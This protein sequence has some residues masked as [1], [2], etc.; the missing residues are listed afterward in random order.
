MRAVRVG[1][2]MKHFEELFSRE[3][4]KEV[5]CFPELITENIED[6]W[7]SGQMYTFVTQG[8][9]IIERNWAIVLDVE[10]YVVKVNE[11]MDKLG[12]DMVTFCIYIGGGE[13]HDA[14]YRFKK[15]P[16]YKLSILENALEKAITR[17]INDFDNGYDVGGCQ[18][19]ANRRN[20][21]LTEEKVL[22]EFVRNL[23]YQFLNFYVNVMSETELQEGSYLLEFTGVEVYYGG[24]EQ[25]WTALVEVSLRNIDTKETEEVDLVYETGIREMRKEPAVS[26]FREGVKYVMRGFQK[27]YPEW[28]GLGVHLFFDKS[29]EKDILEK[30][31]RGKFAKITGTEEDT[32]IIMNR[33]ADM[34]E[35]EFGEVIRKEVSSIKV[36]EPVGLRI[37]F[38]SGADLVFGE[39]GIMTTEGGSIYIKREMNLQRGL[40]NLAKYLGKN[41]ITLGLI[42]VYDYR[43]KVKEDA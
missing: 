42:R 4:Y 40:R 16:E 3:F 32:D 29:M 30:K 24:N 19:I 6:V 36:Y 22:D 23:G 7:E 12:E 33:F 28:K 1:D 8:A 37:V 39:G 35:T 11:H 38:S 18:F 26:E 31:E 14:I 9:R 34:L 2:E 21:L 17:R 25:G 5:E 15:T 13:L 10:L 27:E 41:D 43:R 20:L